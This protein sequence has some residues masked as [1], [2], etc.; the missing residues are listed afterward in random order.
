M[1]MF[2][3][4]ASHFQIFGHGLP[5]INN[6]VKN[7]FLGEKAVELP[8]TLKYLLMTDDEEIDEAKAIEI[9]NHKNNTDEM[10]IHLNEFIIFMITDIYSS[11]LL[12]DPFS[13]ILYK[14]PDDN[15]LFSLECSRY[16]KF[17]DKFKEKLKTVS[18]RCNACKD[19]VWKHVENIHF[20]L[21]SSKTL[22]DI[23]AEETMYNIYTIT[24]IFVNDINKFLLRSFTPL[25]SNFNLICVYDP[26][27]ENR[28]LSKV[29]LKYNVLKEFVDH[30]N[31]HNLKTVKTLN[32][33]FP[34]KLNNGE[35]VQLLAERIYTV[36]DISNSSLLMTP[37]ANMKKLNFIDNSEKIH[38]FFTEDRANRLNFLFDFAK[39]ID[40]N[41]KKNN[42]IID[43]SLNYISVDDSTKKVDVLKVNYS[44]QV[45]DKINSTY[46]SIDSPR[47]KFFSDYAKGK[48]KDRQKS[49]DLLNFAHFLYHFTRFLQDK[50]YKESNNINL[51]YKCKLIFDLWW[52]HFHDVFK[53]EGI[54]VYN[55]RENIIILWFAILNFIN[56]I[57]NGIDDYDE[58]M[59]VNNATYKLIYLKA[60]TEYKKARAFDKEQIQKLSLQDDMLKAYNE[61]SVM[62]I[63][64]VGF[65]ENIY[66]N[67]YK[68]FINKFTTFVRP[69]VEQFFKTK[70]FKNPFN[71]DSSKNTPYS[72]LNSPKVDHVDSGSDSI[73]S[74]DSQD[75]LSIESDNRI[76]EEKSID[77]A[78][79]KKTVD[80]D[81]KEQ[82]VDGAVKEKAVDG[83]IKEQ[84]VENVIDKEKT[85]E[86]VIDKEKTVDSAI[87][88]QTVENVIDKEKAV[89]DNEKEKTVDNA[90]K[91]KA[92]NDIDKEKAVDGAIKEKAVKDIDKE[93]TVDGAIKEQTVKDIDKEKTVEK[94]PV[95]EV[96]LPP[97]SLSKSNKLNPDGKLTIYVSPQ[98][99][100]NT[101]S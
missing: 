30:C 15:Q 72:P 43:Y 7:T 32:E 67:V 64:A 36:Q 48:H 70:K 94:N 73:R 10:H 27:N 3:L 57:I 60:N 81:I 56:N 74:E 1:L 71:K 23:S 46:D 37:L 6:V 63:E 97:P 99:D 86:N 91:E 89:K 47:R 100:E 68:D 29:S 16:V 17:F 44:E 35:N 38:A 53:E 24:S 9:F 41:H 88:E 40:N 26:K 18:V 14:S 49:K 92:V 50:T 78:V 101:K 93:K 98:K 12:K 52:Q 79:E 55:I 22:K 69:C 39:E 59:L 19:A 61:L 87:K 90:I 76:T 11:S 42:Y 31:A 13:Q 80:S 28:Q 51:N 2:F 21:T 34:T 8:D 75:I 66:I 4:S 45:F 82:T 85:V 5:A 25:N 62:D 33:T 96:L 20:I 65:D 95:A 58:T 77:S 84:T 54:S 83:A